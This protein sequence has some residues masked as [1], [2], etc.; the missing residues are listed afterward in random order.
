M[1]AIAG[2]TVEAENLFIH[3]TASWWNHILLEHTA[4]LSPR[5]DPYNILVVVHGVFL[6]TMITTLLGNKQ[7][8]CV[9]GVVIGDGKCAN[10]SVTI[11]DVDRRGRGI[12]TKY[13]DASHIRGGDSDIDTNVDE[14]NLK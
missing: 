12:V 1:L 9:G 11:I 5:N 7:I 4:S 6:K 10:G 14:M 2:D 13:G 3:R 8:E